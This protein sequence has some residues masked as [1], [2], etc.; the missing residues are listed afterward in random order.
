VKIKEKRRKKITKEKT[1]IT[2]LKFIYCTRRPK[3]K[4]VLRG[5]PVK[6]SVRPLNN[7][8]RNARLNYNLHLL[9]SYNLLKLGKHTYITRLYFS[10]TN[11]ILSIIGTLNSIK[12]KKNLFL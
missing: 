9:P 2:A 1:T 3:I 4:G 6:A 7:I 10:Y 12:K 11:A 8:S 5:S